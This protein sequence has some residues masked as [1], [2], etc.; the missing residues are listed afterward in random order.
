MSEQPIEIPNEFLKFA[1]G[2]NE[3]TLPLGLQGMV[4]KAASDNLT[5][6]ERPVCRAF[7]NEVLQQITDGQKLRD[8]LIGSGA[9]LYIEG[10]AA[11]R[12]LLTLMRDSV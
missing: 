2:L 5:P 12:Y 11:S 10:P 8:L 1:S 9:R 4:E 6:A 7:L 3:R